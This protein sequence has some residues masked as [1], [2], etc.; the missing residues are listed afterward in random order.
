M[1]IYTVDGSLGFVAQNEV[2]VTVQREFASIGKVCIFR[3]T[4]C[5]INNIPAAG[6]RCGTMRTLENIY[7]GVLR[8]SLSLFVGC[9]CRINVVD[10]VGIVLDASD[11]D[12]LCGHS[13]AV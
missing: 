9:S 3:I 1:I 4:V 5:I 7:F 6:K 11:G 8:R 10:T 12:I 13:E 2:N